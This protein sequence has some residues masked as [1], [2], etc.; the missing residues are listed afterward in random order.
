MKIS[1]RALKPIAKDIQILRNDL[2]DFSN[3]LHNGKFKKAVMEEIA[4]TLYDDISEIIDTCIDKYYKDYQPKFYKRT[5]SLYKVYKLQYRS[6]YFGW[7][8]DFNLMPNVH[9]VDNEYIYKYMFEQGYHGGANTIHA[10]KVEQW[11]AHPHDGQPWYRTAPAVFEKPPYTAWSK[12]Y[13]AKSMPPAIRIENELRN[14]QIGKSKILGRGL[15]DSCQPAIDL[16]GGRYN[17]FNYR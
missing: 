13:A 12:Y 4:V 2:A 8:F 3:D 9:R 10:D 7:V 1:K 6:G 17:I 16:I 11:G 15:K 5:K 14:Y